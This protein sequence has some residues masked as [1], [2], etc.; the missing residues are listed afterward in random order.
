MLREENEMVSRDSKASDIEIDEDLMIKA[1]Q[2]KNNV[3]LYDIEEKD[4]EDTNEN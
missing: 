4:N 2:D 3:E 1:S